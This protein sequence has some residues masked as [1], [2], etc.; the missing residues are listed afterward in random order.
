MNVSTTQG[1]WEWYK[2]VVRSWLEDPLVEQFGGLN[3]TSLNMDQAYM[4]GVSYRN[5]SIYS[6]SDDCFRCPFELQKTLEAGVPST[7][8]VSTSR[9]AT[10]R[11]YEDVREQYMSA[12]NA[13]SLICQLRPD[14]GEFGVYTLNATGEGCDV[15]TDKEPVNIYLRK[16]FNILCNY[17]HV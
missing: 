1:N 4:T 3:M 14:L 16:S 8:V 11:V 13:T 9:R 5:V 10:W 6:V 15:R 7:F 2:E 17:P 12:A